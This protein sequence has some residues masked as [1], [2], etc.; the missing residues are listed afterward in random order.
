MHAFESGS[1]VYIVLA[2]D[3]T[4]D[5]P[6][7]KGQPLLS[8]DGSLY[9]CAVCHGTRKIAVVLHEPYKGTIYQTHYNSGDGNTYYSVDTQNVDRVTGIPTED[10]HIP[11]IKDVFATYDEAKATADKHNEKANKKLQRHLKRRK[12]EY[13]KDL[14]PVSCVVTERS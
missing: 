12:R 3:T 6:N 2:R 5:C 8:A 1:T 7:C 9:I 14:T 10:L 4:I 11:Y 13:T